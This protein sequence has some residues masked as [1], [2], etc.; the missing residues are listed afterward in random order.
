[1][2]ES[3]LI[4]R[5]DQGLAWGAIFIAVGLANLIPGA[6]PGAGL[7]PIGAI[8]LGLNLS[9]YRRGI[10]MNGL[11]IALGAAALLSGASRLLR[12]SGLALP[13]LPTLLL[14]L[15]AVFLAAGAVRRTRPQPD[16]P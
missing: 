6:P 2:N 7:A 8:L 13:F 11:S 5:R 3:K 9:R 14:A 15:G 10:R 12:P 16:R 4:D 1:M